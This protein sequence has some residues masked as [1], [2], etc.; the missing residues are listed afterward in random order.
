M[1]GTDRKTLERSLA[2]HLIEAGK[3][4]EPALDRVLRLQ[5]GNEERL[6]ALLVKLGFAGERDVAEALAEQLGLTIAGAADY[7]DAP[8]LEGQ[9][10]HQFLTELGVLPLAETADGLVLAMVDPLDRYA[11]RAVEMASGL[12]VRPVLALPS[13]LEAAYARL[14]QSAAAPVDPL[15]GKGEEGS[16][17]AY[18][19]DV[20]RLRDLASE[21][22]VIRLV[23]QLIT[24]AIESR[25]SDVHIEPFQNR[26]A[27]RYR[28]DGV[29]REIAAPPLRLKAAITSRIKIM[30]KLNIAERRLPQD[31]RIRITV[32]GTDFDL[33]VSTAPTMHGESVVMRILDRS[34]LVHDLDALGFAP[35][36]LPPFL[37]L[38][39]QPQGILLVT[40]PTGSGK[41]TTLYTSLMRLN[42]PEKKLFTV[43]DPIEYQLDGV[44]QIQVKPQIGLSF[45]HIL[46]SILRQDPDIIMIGEMRDLDTAQIA[47][48]AALTGHLVLSTLHTNSAAATVTRLLDMGVNG[49]LVTSTLNGALAQRLVRRLCAQCREPYEALPELVAEL[50]LPVTDR[51]R[52]V[53][54]HRARGCAACR[55]TGYKGR[56]AVTELL[57]MSDGIRRLVLRNAEAGEI[58]RLAVQEGMRTMYDDGLRQ[59]LAG[60]TSIEEVL[61][62]TRDI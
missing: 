40:G 21:G 23:G 25:A 38:L 1:D 12:P 37:R 56:I 28:I 33:R 18:L 55:D 22:P 24:K 11:Q 47:I 58:H 10:N 52:P 50:R 31:G 14:Y 42:A 54:L 32:H 41:T 29:L 27:V 46:R 53:T 35:D 13:E 48:Q 39:D 49:Y 44:N 5:R 7:P 15:A 34:S 9:I 45:A 20:D 4:E 8:L 2:A 43:E 51:S 59:A 16:D 19:E 61:R 30:A 3:L 6:E 26:I 36:V 62:V 57:V 17:D 60:I